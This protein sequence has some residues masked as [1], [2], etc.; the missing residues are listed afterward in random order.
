MISWLPA[1]C[2][3]F[4]EFPLSWDRLKGETR[5]SHVGWTKSSIWKLI[6]CC[7]RSMQIPLCALVLGSNS[8]RLSEDISSWIAPQPRGSKS[9]GKPMWKA[10]FT[11]GAP[12]N[13]TLCCRSLCVLAFR[14]DLCHPTFHRYPAVN[15]G[16]NALA[17][18]MSTDEVF[19]H[20]QFFCIASSGERGTRH[21]LLHQ[22]ANTPFSRHSCP[23]GVASTLDVGCIALSWPYS[24]GDVVVDL[25]RRLWSMR[26][27]V[28][29]TRNQFV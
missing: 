27:V 3:G 24:F 1:S 19:G 18:P 15:V 8:P 28:A 7:M 29:S 6:S 16:R 4:Y 2:F 12:S 11:V 20:V 14:V 25:C 9:S 22:G 26:S 5:E 13:F 21:L 17:V 10:S 23:L